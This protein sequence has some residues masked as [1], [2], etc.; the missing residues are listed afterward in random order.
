MTE[1]ILFGKLPAHGDFVARGLSDTQV[2]RLDDYLTASLSDAATLDDFDA[3]YA[4]APAWRF[5]IALDDRMF[6]GVL[7]PSVD[8]VGRQFPIL[9]GVKAAGEQIGVL[10]DACEAHLYSAFAEGQAADEV[11]ATLEGFP[12]MPVS[13]ELPTPGWYLEDED[14]VVVDRL[15]GS[16]PDGLMTRMMQAAR[17]VS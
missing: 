6:C 9:V 7:A 17:Q 5:V 13:S 12:D 15:E 16:F 10:I 1:A 11:F 8:K 4:V 2:G 14:K 3:L